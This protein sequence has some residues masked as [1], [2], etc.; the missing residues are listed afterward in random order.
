MSEDLFY[1]GQQNESK[2]DIPTSVFVVPKVKRMALRFKTRQEMIDDYGID[3]I[4]D[5][6]PSHGWN[7]RMDPMCG[8]FIRFYSADSE[9]IEDFDYIT[10][11]VYADG[12]MSEEPLETPTQLVTIGDDYCGWTLVKHSFLTEYDLDA[13]HEWTYHSDMFTMDELP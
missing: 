4:G 1:C 7:N 2:E 13:F 10:D 5:P 8:R 12:F 11:E 9:G 6:R 3:E